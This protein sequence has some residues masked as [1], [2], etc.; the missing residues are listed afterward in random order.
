[1]KLKNSQMEAEI[2]AA[3]EKCVSLETCLVNKNAEIDDKQ[4]VIEK[5]EKDMENFKGSN[6]FLSLLLLKLPSA[7]LL[8]PRSMRS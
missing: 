3:N 1:M 5:M 6:L 4:T 7:E 2:C 8:Q